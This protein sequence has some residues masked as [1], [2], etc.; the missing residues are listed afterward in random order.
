[1]TSKKI[2]SLSELAELFDGVEERQDC[3][4]ARVE[5]SAGVP[6]SDVPVMPT[7]PTEHSH[8][9]GSGVH[10]AVQI[11]SPQSTC[12][13]KTSQEKRENK[14]REV[15]AKL[16]EANRQVRKFKERAINAEYKIKKMLEQGSEID[17]H[18]KSLQD[19]NII[20]DALITKIKALSCPTNDKLHQVNPKPQSSDDSS[21]ETMIRQL[22]AQLSEPTVNKYRAL[23]QLVIAYNALQGVEKI[24]MYQPT[25]GCFTVV[26]GLRGFVTDKQEFYDVSDVDWNGFDPELVVDYQVYSAGIHVGTGKIKLLKNLRQTRRDQSEV[27]LETPSPTEQQILAGK[28][29]LLVTW[30]ESSRAAMKRRLESCGANVDTLGSRTI[31]TARIKSDLQRDYDLKYVI[32]HGVHHKTFYDAKELQAADGRIRILYN[33]GVT[34]VECDAIAQLQ[35]KKPLN[36]RL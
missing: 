2:A 31:S 6:K 14:L 34:A 30:H 10:R 15:V 22:Q 23:P 8:S 3:Q 35:N 28:R 5:S 16:A 11:S 29:I 19:M 17:I 7:V 21:I 24:T 4:T 27:K 36:E 26:N 18:G 33:P 20:Q 1:M 25:T 9:G 12:Q 13:S 32:I